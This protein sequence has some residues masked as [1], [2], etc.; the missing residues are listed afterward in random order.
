[1]TLKASD[2]KPNK[3]EQN[4]KMSTY[5]YGGHR[6]IALNMFINLNKAVG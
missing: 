2:L 5:M 4:K 3:K 6:P 1:M